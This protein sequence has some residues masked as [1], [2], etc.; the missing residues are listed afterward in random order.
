MRFV[1]GKQGD[2]QA[3]QKRHHARL[4]QAFRC[5]V[6]HFY[7]TAL[8]PV[9][10]VALLLGIQR[11][12]Q[13]RCRH[14]ELF[15]GCHLI[16]HQCDQWRH[17]HRQAIAQ[18]RRNLKTQ[19]LAAAGRHQHQSVATTGHALNNV[20]LTAT[21]TVVAEDVLEYALSLFE[22]KNSRNRRNTPA[23]AASGAASS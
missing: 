18:E 2:V 15:K 11:R 10:Q 6:E 20:T 14:P 1:D 12:V 17:H 22:H 5:Q 8:D 21:E 3:L 4:Y 23:Q 7:F 16:V 13:G 9:R 19:G